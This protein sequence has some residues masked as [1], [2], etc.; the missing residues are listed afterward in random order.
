MECCNNGCQEI[1]A[2]A[3]DET[4]SAEHSD[5]ALEDFPVPTATTIGDM[6]VKCIRLL[7]DN[8]A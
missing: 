6:I 2:E 7:S 1:A 5:N 3:N 4:S 8:M